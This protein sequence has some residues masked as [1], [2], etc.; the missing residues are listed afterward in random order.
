MP[1]TRVRYRFVGQ[2][3]WPFRV[4]ITLAFLNMAAFVGL[5]LTRRQW[6][7]PGLA[8]GPRAAAALATTESWS[9]AA[10]FV[11][12]GAA[13]LVAFLFRDRLERVPMPPR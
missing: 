1:L 12:L 6:G 2:A 4:V 3:P 13:F 5:G 7:A 10:H 11:L 8:F 9:F